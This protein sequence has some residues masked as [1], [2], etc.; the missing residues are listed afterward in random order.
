M[1][2]FKQILVIAIFICFVIPNLFQIFKGA[3]HFPFS[4]NPM[5]GH[6]VT[7]SDTL[8]GLSFLT[9]VEERKELDLSKVGLWDVR[10]KRFYFSNI[11]GSSEENSPQKNASPNEKVFI[12]R[13][14][15]FFRKLTSILKSNNIEVSKIYLEHS[16]LTHEGKVI[17]RNIIGYYDSNIQSFDML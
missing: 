4:N 8:A 5:F 6:Y 7:N 12:E 11:Y 9:D 13:N 2:K 15:N 1:G 16:R 17:D 3:E 14:T 10:L